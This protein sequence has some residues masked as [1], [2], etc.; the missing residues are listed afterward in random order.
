MELKEQ[1][2]NYLLNFLYDHIEKAH[3]LQLRAKWEP[4]SVVVWD[5]RLV[6]HSAIVDWDTPVSRHAFRITPQAERPV[7]DLQDLNKEEY[8]VGDVEEALKKILH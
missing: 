2:S 1:E 5:N 8:D 4:N 7:A 3:D 6:V